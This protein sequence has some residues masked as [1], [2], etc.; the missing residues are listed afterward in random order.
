MVKCHLNI[1]FF[2]VFMFNS[3]IRKEKKLTKIRSNHF[4]FIVFNIGSI[5]CTKDIDKKKYSNKINKI[6]AF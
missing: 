2:D 1:R 4:Y 5:F 6:Q 3:L